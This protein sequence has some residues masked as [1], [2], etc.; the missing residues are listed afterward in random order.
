M[1]ANTIPRLTHCGLLREEKEL[2]EQSGEE[3][4]KTENNCHFI[5]LWRTNILNTA[6]HPILKDITEVESTEN[7][8]ASQRHG[9]GFMQE[10]KNTSVWKEAKYRKE[11]YRY[12]VLRDFLKE[13]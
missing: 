6:V 9:T 2:E 8:K 11:T 13:L 7:G 4:D 1:P 10:R 5:N 3:G 12:I